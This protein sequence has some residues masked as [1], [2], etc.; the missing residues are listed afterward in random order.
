MVIDR[1]RSHD[2]LGY[3]RAIAAVGAATAVGWPLYHRFHLPDETQ[4]PLLSNTN[5]LMFYLLGVLWVATKG[6]SGAAIL[7]SLL[8]VAAFDF[9]FVPPYLTFT[10]H[11]Q[12]YLVTFAVM[13]LTALTISTLTHR[14]RARSEEAR[15]AWERVEAEFLRNTLLS[16]VSHELRTPLAAITG[17][18]SALIESPQ[19]IP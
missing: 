19:A 13:L 6:S 7:A 16:G 10:V 14:V 9:C 3:G 11:N 1:W 4:P 8:G 17:A 5:V 12:E 18:V 15:A 2:W